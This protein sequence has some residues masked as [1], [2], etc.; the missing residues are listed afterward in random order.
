MRAYVERFNDPPVRNLISIGGQHQGVSNVPGCPNVPTAKESM[1]HDTSDDLIMIQAD[2]T[3][4]VSDCS[5][6]KKMIKQGVYYD[7]VQN[8]VVQAQYFKDPTR[9]DEYLKKSI[10]LADINNEREVKNPLYKMNLSNVKNFV[11]L[12]FADDTHAVPKES[13]VSFISKD[14]KY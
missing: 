3:R 7:F 12:M 10:F 4:Q 5:W 13:A 9:F 8:R 2:F 6:W 1:Q 11:M 14:Y